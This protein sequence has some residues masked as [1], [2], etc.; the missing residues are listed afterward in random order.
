MNSYKRLTDEQ[1]VT[2]L[3]EAIHLNLSNEFIQLLK[4]EMSRRGL[5]SNRYLFN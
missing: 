5:Q 1:L 3:R 2:A 4:V